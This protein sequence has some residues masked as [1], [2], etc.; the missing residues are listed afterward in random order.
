MKKYQIEFRG[1]FL[2]VRKMQGAKYMAV[3]GSSYTSLS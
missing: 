3:T 1:Y 2:G